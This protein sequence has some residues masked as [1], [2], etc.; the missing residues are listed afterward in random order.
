MPHVFS[1]SPPAAAVSRVYKGEFSQ[2]L[3]VFRLLLLSSAS[4]LL[5]CQSLQ[6]STD[7]PIRTAE[8]QRRAMLGNVGQREREMRT[9]QE[10]QQRQFSV[11]FN[12][13]VEAINNFASRYNA[14]QGTV[15]PK[16]EA[17]KLGKAMRRIQQFEKSLRDDPA[18]FTVPERQA[19]N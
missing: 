3:R 17:D 11:M 16:R 1:E 8:L 5:V 18:P 15:W 12:Q 7:D 4:R 6:A 2:L 13:L 19:V 14:G 10:D 9:R